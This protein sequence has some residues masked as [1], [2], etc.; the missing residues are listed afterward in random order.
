MRHRLR[1]FL[2]DLA[3]NIRRILRIPT[4]DE[5]R[6]E[7]LKA[8]LEGRR[9]TPEQGMSLIRLI[10]MAFVWIRSRP[11]SP[12][13]VFAI[14][15]AFHNLPGEMFSE[16][17]S[18]CRTLEVLLCLKQQAPDVGAIF[19]DEFDDIVGFSHPSAITHD[20]PADGT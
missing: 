4:I 20:A 13:V 17:F 1:L 8:H 16:N 5:R 19:L 15:D 14:A 3:R 6:V 12:A 9:P 10:C 2:E 11:E 7:Y 18:W